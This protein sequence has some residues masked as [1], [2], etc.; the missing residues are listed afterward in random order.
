MSIEKEFNVIAKEY[1]INR[2]RFI[3]CF[4]D[5]YKGATDMILAHVRTP[6]RVLDLGAG[7]GLLTY[8]WY[9]KCP[10]TEYTL[11]DI[12]EEM[13][14]ISKKRFSGIDNIQHKICDY[15]ESL[16]EGEFD[17]V[18]SALS[19]HHL[20]EDKK[21][22]LFQRIFDKLPEGGLFVNYDQ[23]CAGSEKMNCWFDLY[24]GYK[25]NPG[26]AEIEIRKCGFAQ[27]AME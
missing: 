22:L 16:P 19:V 18:I 21:E 17:A 14:D 2:K 6:N 13:L 5:Y 11:I 25:V 12:A 15:T 7:T 10:E 27:E 4:D 8:F 23:F 1:D 24:C 26:P 3:P 20:E 9:Q